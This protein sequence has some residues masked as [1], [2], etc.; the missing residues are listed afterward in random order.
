MQALLPVLVVAVIAG[1]FYFLTQ[2][3]IKRLHTPCDRFSEAFCNAADHVLRGYVGNGEIAYD[4]GDGGRVTLRPVR[5]QPV[6]MQL[7]LQNGI[8]DAVMEQMRIMYGARDE[9]Q[10]LL[11]GVTLVGDKYNSVLNRVYDL[12]NLSFSFL[13][14]PSLVRS[15]E[16]VEELTY[17]LTQQDHIRN[18]TLTAI[19]S[20]TCKQKIATG[21]ENAA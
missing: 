19:V 7:L 2:Y 14:D 13:N 17:F 15:R 6:E 12:A 11:G 16:D 20:D 1:L 8:D 4:V 3:R 9:A 5:E 10:A 18:V 21:R